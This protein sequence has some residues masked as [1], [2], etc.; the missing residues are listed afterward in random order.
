MQFSVWS[1]S[2]LTR[3]GLVRSWVPAAGL[4]KSASDWLDR[5]G[6]DRGG[7]HVHIDGL[8]ADG[9]PHRV[10]WFAIS[11]H[12][13][14]PMIPCIASIVLARKLAR[15][16]LHERGARMCVDMMTLDDFKA[17]VRDLDIRFEVHSDA[18]IT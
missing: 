14:G 3:V 9:K 8:S 18:E 13:D 15:G 17:A 5:F 11:A 12:G 1:M 6:T 2:W 7:M 10:R 4:L 16:Q